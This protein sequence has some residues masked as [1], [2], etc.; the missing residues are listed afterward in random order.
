MQKP[1][2]IKSKNGK[3]FIDIVKSTDGYYCLQLFLVKYDEEEGCSY[4][5]RQFP[6]PS[7]KYGTIESALEEA[8]RL[9]KL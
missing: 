4:E 7:G 8:E 2:R 3:R 5:V 6:D 1:N 9:V